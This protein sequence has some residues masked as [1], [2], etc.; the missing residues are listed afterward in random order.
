MKKPKDSD[1]YVKSIFAWAQ[2]VYKDEW[3][4]Y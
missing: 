1:G 2:W 4:I 3:L